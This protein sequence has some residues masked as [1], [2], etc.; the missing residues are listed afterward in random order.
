[1]KIERMQLL[2]G[3]AKTIYIY[4][5]SRIHFDATSYLIQVVVEWNL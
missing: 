5:W 4:K 1:M 2:F 3:N